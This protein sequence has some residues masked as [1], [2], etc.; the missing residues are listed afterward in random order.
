MLDIDLWKIF[1]EFFHRPTRNFFSYLAT[2]H[3]NLP[4]PDFLPFTGLARHLWSSSLK[5][6]YSCFN[7]TK[8]H[9]FTLL[10][11]LGE[12]LI[13]VNL[14]SES[15]PLKNILNDIK[16]FKI[17]KMN[18]KTTKFILS[19]KRL[20]KTNSVFLKRYKLKPIFFSF[21][22]KTKELNMEVCLYGSIQI[23]PLFGIGGMVCGKCPY[24][25]T[26]LN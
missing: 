10:G 7:S 20:R 1:L 14:N 25:Y 12:K 17:K 3:Q 18:S 26:K 16:K 22:D 5:F 21:G 6:C 2:V 11:L 8:L 4:G 15:F 23:L 13:L 24:R 9:W 19:A